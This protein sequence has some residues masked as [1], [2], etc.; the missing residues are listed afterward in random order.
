MISVT[1]IALGLI[2][3]V[4]ILFPKQIASLLPYL[5]GIMMILIGL[6]GIRQI[7]EKFR[8]APDIFARKLVLLIVGISFLVQGK[9]A[10]V[11]I[12]IIW[13]VLG[14]WKAAD[15][16]VDF[17]EAYQAKHGVLPALENYLFV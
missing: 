16:F 6:I 3:I 7:G 17:W 2:G 8:Q 1:Q 14:L 13:A 12:G 15:A 4:C 11:P 9:T 10:L 5:M